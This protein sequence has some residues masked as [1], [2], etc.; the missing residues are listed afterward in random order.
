MTK[1]IL[2]A[3]LSCEGLT[4]TEEEKKLFAEYNPLGVSL[5]ARNF[6]SKQQAKNLI[7]EIRET[8]GRD[9]VL[10]AVDEEGGRV[11]RLANAGFP[12]Y[13][14]AETL[15][16]IV[17][18]CSCWHAVLISKNLRS[19]GINVNY[20]PVVDKKTNPQSEVLTS[21]C[22]SADEEE[23]ESRAGIMA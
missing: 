13:T 3:M 23:I 19:L 20:A 9:D 1:P 8:I 16:S 6:K 17:E 4:L 7:D 14:S 22:F 18:I 10:I 12:V 15:G 21:R 11:S 5:F 2:A